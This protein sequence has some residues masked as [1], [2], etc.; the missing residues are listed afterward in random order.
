MAQL[1]VVNPGV[2]LNVEGIHSLSGVKDAVITPPPDLEE[3]IGHVDEA[4]VGAA[5]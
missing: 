1:K 4:Q 5:L 3:D 2:D